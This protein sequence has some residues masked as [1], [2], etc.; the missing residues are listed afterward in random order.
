VF[1]LSAMNSSKDLFW[2]LKTGQPPKKMELWAAAAVVVQ[3]V[4]VVLLAAVAAAVTHLLA[5]RAAE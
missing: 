1:V 3:V 2:T 5:F 4:V